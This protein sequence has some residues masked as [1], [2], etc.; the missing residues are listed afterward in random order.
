MSDAKVGRGRKEW[1]RVQSKSRSQSRAIWLTA[2]ALVSVM[3]VPTFAGSL[4]GILNQWAYQEL[5]INW[6]G[7]FVRRGLYG[8]VMVWLHDAAGISGSAP[9]AIVFIVGTTLQIV[10]LFSLLWQYRASR[11]VLLLV[12]F[13]PV[14]LLFPVYDVGAFWRKEL[15]LNI[16]ILAHALIARRCLEG[17]T[18][19]EMY[20]VL[21]VFVLTPLLVVN[22]LIYEPQGFFLGVHLALSLSVLRST[23]PDDD[24]GDLFVYLAVG[25]A[26]VIA[27]VPFLLSVV[28]SGSPEKSAA[29][30]QAVDGWSGVVGSEAIDAHG[31]TLAESSALAARIIDDPISSL[32]FLLAFLVGPVMLALVVRSEREPDEE[33]PLPLWAFVPPMALFVIGWDYGRWIQMI[34]FAAVAYM[35]HFPVRTGAFR[36]YSGRGPYAWG[37]PFLLATW[38]VLY[39]VAWH[40]PHCCTV[41]SPA[42]VASGFLPLWSGIFTAVMQAF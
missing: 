24:E 39:V 29:M 4:A 28:S 7:G 8:S 16:A 23:R 38:A 14:L 25:A 10:L 27:L 31:G 30:F 41:T 42:S 22:T 36:P 26:Y 11:L 20:L 35:L 3:W 40:M 12:A 9:T 1:E 17:R 21:L 15:F 33:W 37:P 34:A 19:R 2:L 18:S 5:L 6:Q 13:S 32:V